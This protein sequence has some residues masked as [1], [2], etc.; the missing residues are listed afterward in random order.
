MGC[1]W[2]SSEFSPAFP[3]S[4]KIFVNGVPIGLRL[5]T[6][7]TNVVFTSRFQECVPNKVVDNGDG[8]LRG[9]R[10]CGLSAA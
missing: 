1:I 6:R 2:L 10:H 4:R 7:G 8:S 9:S 3:M 5:L